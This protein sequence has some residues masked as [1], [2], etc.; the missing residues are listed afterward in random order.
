MMRQTQRRTTR[1]LGQYDQMVADKLE[2][3]GGFYNAHSHLDRGDTLPDKYLLHAGTTSLKAAIL[4]LRAKQDMVGYLHTG[5]AYKEK[6]LFRR[7]T[8]LIERLIAYG[9]T[10]LDT[11]I[12]ATT[13]EGNDG[14]IAIRV[15]QQLKARFAKKIRIRIG[16]MPIFGFKKGTE[17]WNIFEKAA[18]SGAD[19]LVTLPEK[20]AI[21]TGASSDGKIGYIEHMRMVMEL[22]YELKLEVHHHV[23]QANSPD[24]NGTE[25]LLSALDFIR[26]PKIPNHDAPA[27]WV[28]HMI[29]PSAYPEKRFAQLIK[30]M[31]R[32]NVGL[33]C[34][35]S[36]ALS[37]RQLRPKSAPTHNSIARV[38]ELL[39]C[40][41]PVRFGTDNIHDAFVPQCSGDPLDEIRVA[42]HSLRIAAV[43]VLAKVGAGVPL[44]NVDRGVVGE[45]LYQDLKVFRDIKKNWNMAVE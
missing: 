20:D 23:D 34:C 17:R 2:E 16:P 15:A 36:A 5:P 32:H 22:A 33:I 43:N 39:K 11:C 6:D 19:F 30:G 13:I 45:T 1:E 26:Q 9:T 21:T 29:S 27:T 24:E 4:P 7:M 3:S 25:V 14:L 41:V 31:L 12:D 40:K 42:G 38:L 18:R 44:N 8:K 35:P 28:V 37:M 10:R